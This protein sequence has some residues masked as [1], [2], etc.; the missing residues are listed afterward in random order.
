MP[1]VNDLWIRLCTLMYS[2]QHKIKCVDLLYARLQVFYDENHRSG[3]L[4]S[5]L[6]QRTIAN[7]AAHCIEHS[8][9]P[10]ACSVLVLHHVSLLYIVLQCAALY[11]FARAAQGKNRSYSYGPDRGKQDA[12]HNIAKH[13]T[14]HVRGAGLITARLHS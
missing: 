5:H 10:S 14:M 9:Q 8:P 1:V 4:S 2:N 6:M 12:Q 13:S 7:C 3:G 11:C